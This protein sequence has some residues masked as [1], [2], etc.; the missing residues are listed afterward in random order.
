[1]PK[2]IKPT[3]KQRHFS[4]EY[5]LN[6]K[7]GRQAA[8]DAHY[9]PNTAVNAHSDILAK[10][11]TQLAIKELK[12]KTSTDFTLEEQVKGIRDYLEGAP[13]AAKAAIRLKLYEI[14]K[15]SGETRQNQAPL[16]SEHEE[17]QAFMKEGAITT[18]MSTTMCPKCNDLIEIE[19]QHD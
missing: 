13:Q 7:S 18:L 10:P 12:A 11:G 4:R 1:M 15:R 17:A 5:T 14:I 3:R 9:S 19:P 16:L 2:T 8:K 6:H